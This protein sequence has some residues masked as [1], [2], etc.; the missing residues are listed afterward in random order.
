MTAIRRLSNRRL[1][2]ATSRVARL[3][4]L[5][6]VAVIPLGC[7]DRADE[8][9]QTGLLSAAYDP[10]TGRLRLI[11]YD[12]DE[13]GTVDTWTYMDGSRLLRI[14]IDRDENGRMERWEHYDEARQLEKIGLSS[15][16][17]GIEDT[18]AY[19]GP[20]G[21]MTMLE[22]SNSRDGTV[23]R[24]QYYENGVLVRAEQDTTAN[25]VVD[26]WEHF[27]N[28]QLVTVS[29]DVNGDGR[30]DRRM[31]YDEH[32]ALVSIESEPDANGEF[33]KTVT[34]PGED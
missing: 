11:E 9:Q 30:S 8:S 14:E 19:H 20:D 33:T 28:G 1:A 6:V 5:I 4:T 24:W 2:F 34:P 15:A 23:D 13:N 32:A 22:L 7:I 16:G 21:Q 25:G 31:T 18:W 12:A 26:K 29:L 3:V 10:E 27:E 17:D